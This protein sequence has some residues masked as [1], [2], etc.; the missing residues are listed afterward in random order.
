MFRFFS[1]I[2]K[3]KKIIFFALLALVAGGIFI[4]QVSNADANSFACTTTSL[5][6]G[7]GIASDLW[8]C[9]T[10]SQ[11]GQALGYDTQTVGFWSA[12]V[13]GIATF[14]MN[15]SAGIAGYVIELLTDF[16]RTLLYWNVTSYPAFLTGWTTSRDLANM[17]IVLG[18][19]VVG[20]AFTLRLEGYGSKKVLISLI[21]VAL[22]VNFS[23]VV[24]GVIIDASNITMRCFVEGKCTAG[25]TAAISSYAAKDGIPNPLGG[26]STSYIGDRISDAIKKF[27]DAQLS[28]EDTLKDTAKFA[29]AAA[30]VTLMYI[31]IIVV[32]G[33]MILVL[34]ERYVMLGILYML[35]PLAFFAYVF[36]A[37]KKYFTRWWEEFIKWAFIGVG[38]A[39][40]LWIAVK[41]VEK[42][43]VP[44]TE[45][46]G[47]WT[48]TI[49]PFALFLALILLFVS[50]KIIRKSSVFANAVMGVVKTAAGVAI[51]AGIG[52]ATAGGS[53]ALKAAGA[54]RGLANAKDT[55]TGGLEKIGLVQ[56]GTTASNQRKRLDE[57]KKKL[58]NITDNGK[59]AKIAEQRAFTHQQSLD[60]A[61]AAEILA[62]RNAFGA[63]DANKRD[64][65][66]A[67]A[68]AFGVSAET[69]TKGRP[70]TFAGATEKEASEKVWMDQAKA[71]GKSFEET[72]ATY[73][74]SPTEIRDAQTA[75]RQR[76][77]TENALGLSPV[78]NKDVRSKLIEEDQKA[79]MA[80][81]RTY[82]E[83]L[84]LTKDFVPDA[85]R[86]ASAK[87]RI[88]QERIQKAFSKLGGEGIGKLP[89]EALKSRE[90]IESVQANRISQSARFLS[91]QGVDDIKSHIPYLKSEMAKAGVG[92]DRYIKLKEIHDEVAVL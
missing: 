63:V 75:I 11:I 52:V 56:K 83:A 28:S 17:L 54:T 19:V 45:P 48:T 41:I 37:T 23:N 38:A 34:F 49:D 42:G 66:A 80:A 91:G 8:G 36:P 81:G 87:E 25:T 29:A 6:P 65:V 9:G 4:P 22:L 7:I 1:Q 58:E 64:S 18:F 59:L 24:A 46:N 26:L 57:S 5:L 13:K 44:Y 53:F 84:A 35:A 21:L 92:T 40:F 70:E 78:S 62:G 15:T 39:F 79:Y 89:G 16:F 50:Y 10:L 20:I 88:T 61:A 14:S 77:T 60:K 67:H 85:G 32:F 51:G 71:T 72:K 27:K 90:F 68:K 86:V 55:V 2:L 74:P 33:Y 31:L 12:I 30:Q 76:K 47:A 82:E 73:R 69:F 43:T 3:Q